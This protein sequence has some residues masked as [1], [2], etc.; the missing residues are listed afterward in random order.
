[1]SITAAAAPRA[2]AVHRPHSPQRAFAV[3]P[4]LAGK[5]KTLDAMAPIGP[6]VGMQPVFLSYVD[7]GGTGNLAPGREVTQSAALNWPPNASHALVMLRGFGAAFVDG[8]GHLTDHHL[9]D[10]L[11]EWFFPDNNNVGCNFLLRD[12]GID[13]GVNMWSEGIVLYFS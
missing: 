10:I 6:T 12:Q 9:G 5:I 8:D 11:I 1:M 13:E 3:A 2:Q 7:T 4:H